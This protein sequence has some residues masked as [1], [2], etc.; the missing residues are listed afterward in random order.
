ME[1]EGFIGLM[2]SRQFRNIC[3]KF[4]HHAGIRPNYIF[5]SDNPAAV[6]NMI[7]A[8]MGVGFWPEFS[9]GR[10]H[11]PNVKLL[12]VSDLQ[13]SRDLIVSR[14]GNSD[15]ARTFFEYLKVCLT[16]RR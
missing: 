13:C 7:A 2:G 8:N 9:W 4:C 15:I 6:Q 10:L 3:D 11:N 5:E 14:S 1:K 16:E 12:S